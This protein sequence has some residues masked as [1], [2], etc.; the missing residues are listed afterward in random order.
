MLNYQRVRFKPGWYK[1]D[2]WSQMN[3]DDKDEQILSKSF[4]RS[5]YREKNSI[6]AL[7]QRVDSMKT[8]GNYGLI[9]HIRVCPEK[10]PF[11]ILQP[12]LGQ[13]E[14]TMKKRRRFMELKAC[15]VE[16]AHPLRSK[17][18]DRCDQIL[19]KILE[20]SI[21]STWHAKNPFFLHQ[22]YKS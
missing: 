21:L 2:K 8:P 5:I 7:I 10:C 11:N 18:C 6:N 17:K 1:P 16:G 3:M 19:P 9:F 20:L 13:E 14:E 12:I 15:R 22:V 4:Y